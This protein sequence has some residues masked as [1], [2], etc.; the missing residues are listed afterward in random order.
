M[1]C[2]SSEGSHEK[3][4]KGLPKE[5]QEIRETGNQKKEIIARLRAD[6]RKLQCVSSIHEDPV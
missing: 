5:L 1:L 6:A 2:E 3:M 4:L